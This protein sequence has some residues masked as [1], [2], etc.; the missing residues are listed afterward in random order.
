MV[1]HQ[2]YHWL[3]ATSWGSEV[4]TLQLQPPRCALSVKACDF[5]EPLTLLFTSQGLLPKVKDAA[6]PKFPSLSHSANEWFA[7][8]GI[9]FSLLLDGLG[10]IVRLTGRLPGKGQFKAP[11]GCP[12][13]PKLLCTA[14]EPGQFD[15]ECNIPLHLAPVFSSRTYSM[16]GGAGICLQLDGISHECN[17]HSMARV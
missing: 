2:R 11:E 13:T 8:C 5:L 1:L 14:S 7:F 12:C 16:H 6:G 3:P 17:V 15:T 10:K 9:A 4:H